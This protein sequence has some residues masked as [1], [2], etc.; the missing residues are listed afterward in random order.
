MADNRFN[1]GDAYERM[2]GVWSRMVGQEFLDWISLPPGL[3]CIDVGCGNGAF[4]EQLVER[5]A[6][7]EVQGL[8]PSTAQ[9][10]FARAR[11][12]ANIA[13][14]R[15]GDAMALPFP[16]A[17]FDAAIMALV[18]FFVPEPANG[19][20]EMVRVVR[21]GGI[22]AAYAWD[23]PG[24]G[25]PMQPILTEIRLLGHE[26]LGTPRPEVSEI[27]ALRGLWQAGGLQQIETL[28][29][30]VRRK[31]ADFEDYWTTGTL[32]GSIGATVAKLTPNEIAT[33][34]EGLRAKIPTDSAG[35][36][37]YSAFANAVKGRVP[38]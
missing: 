29:I 13:E 4:T 10:A 25:F 38:K 23:L 21:P 11:H 16:D 1:D 22:V 14:F 32:T 3:R 35:R 5:C 20:A 6:P 26:P 18:I 7:S 28:K 12:N 19:V 36:I 34:K 15:V 33:A 24:G 30:T 9:V 8:D 17:R 27:G 31:F 37:T 2:M